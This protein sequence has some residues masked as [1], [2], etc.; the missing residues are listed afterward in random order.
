MAARAG[1][2]RARRRRIVRRLL[3]ALGGLAAVGAV[4]ALLAGYRLVDAARDLRAARTQL[5]SAE[6]AI[7]EGRVAD[8]RA[9][10]AAASSRLIGAQR[11]LSKGRLELDIVRAL[12]IAGD[13]L[14][15]LRESV[16]L[17]TQLANGGVRILDAAKPL[18]GESGRLDLSLSAG[19][20]PLGPVRAVLA[21]ID[22]LRTSL[23]TVDDLEEDPGLLVG[24]VQDL[25]DRITE[26][27]L[28]RR[29]Q[30]D[31]LSAALGLL[32]EMAGG[33]GNRGYL[34]AV[35][36]TSEMRGSGGMILNYGGLLGIEGRFSLPGFG[37][38]DDLYLREPIPR[39]SVPQV[40]DDYV[41]RWDGFEPFRLWRNA[42]LAGDFSVVAPVLLEMGRAATA[43]QLDGVIQI[44]PAGLAALL[45]GVGPVEV[46]EIGEVNAQ[47]VVDVVLYEAYAKYPG[48]QARS[49]V[50]EAVARAA[51]NRLVSGNFPS[52]RPLGAA[53]GEAVRGRHLMMYGETP[54]LT[55]NLERLGAQGTLPRPRGPDSF[56]LTVQN[57]SA[58]KLDY[59]VDTAVELTGDR[60][61]GTLSPVTAKVVVRNSAPPGATEPKYVFGPF[62]RSQQAGLYRA[63]VTLYLP[64]GT[65]IGAVTGDPTRYPAI[66]LTEDGRPLVSYTIDLPAGQRHEAVIELELAPRKPSPYEV[67]LVPSPRVRP[68]TWRIALDT[69]E[70]PLVRTLE[71]RESVVVRPEVEPAPWRPHD[72]G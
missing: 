68:T 9:S 62:D 65:N 47:N 59:F 3:I 51:F 12:P 60:R 55:A 1:W 24:P 29:E 28:D 32:H 63:V 58:N 72:E 46:P 27:V 70:G 48:I 39:E 21:E 5:E 30:L 2:R 13:N 22:L 35:A 17:A 41:A 37:R 67:I 50:L 31:T 44:D 20:V 4:V 14:V 54:E 25:H 38:I 34:I 19:Q 11:S 53:L 33:R 36:N 26:E 40:P 61:P 18:V 57:V 43:A 15:D 42:N 6:T 49:D 56:H 66:R 16:T 64:A 52:L 69:G 71:L 10:L 7:A 45:E 8:A 23:P